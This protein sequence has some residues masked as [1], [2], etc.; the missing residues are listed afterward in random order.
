M[1]VA[2]S[3]LLLPVLY[4]QPAPPTPRAS[5]LGTWRLKAVHIIVQKPDGTPPYSI[6]PHITLGFHAQTFTKDG[7]WTHWQN[8]TRWATGT[9]QL[10]KGRLWYDGSKRQSQYQVRVLP[11]S[12]P[13]THGYP[14]RLSYCEN[15]REWRACARDYNFRALS[16][17]PPKTHLFKRA[18]STEKT[19][20]KKGDKTWLQKSMFSGPRGHSS[21]L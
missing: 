19:H 18:S 21:S 11:V 5:I 12:S 6:D 16:A 2:P 3:L 1:N 8:G 13:S 17:G 7:R 14:T 20:P 9:Y 4:Q 15:R 10:H